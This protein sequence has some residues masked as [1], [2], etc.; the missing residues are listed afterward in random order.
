MKHISHPEIVKRLKQAH[1]Q[2][3]S[4]LAM[5]ADGRSC[6]ELAQ[7]LQAVESIIR[8]SKRTLI[9]DHM[10]HCIGD[11]L[12]EGGLSADAAL[13]EFKTLSKYL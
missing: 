13:R 11:A 8:T 5:F 7:Q 3:A 12:G 2:L 1:G 9:H 6:T 4:V 10:E